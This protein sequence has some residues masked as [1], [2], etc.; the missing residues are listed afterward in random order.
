MTKADLVERVSERIKL[1]KKQTELIVN[2]LFTSIT[3]ALTR[4]DK[5]ELRGFGSFRVRQRHSRDGRNPKTGQGVHIPPQE[6]PLLQGR[7]RIARDGGQLMPAYRHA[8]SKP[9]PCEG[10]RT[11]V[12]VRT[13]NSTSR[14]P[15]FSYRPGLL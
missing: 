8:S 12:A 14:D 7:Q 9:V 15:P 2:T 4:G 6:S 10:G 5:V 13:A 11:R 3:D 1:T